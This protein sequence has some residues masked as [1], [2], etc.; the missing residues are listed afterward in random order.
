MINNHIRS[1]SPVVCI[2]GNIL[3]GSLGY[4]AKPGITIK[5]YCPF[6][7]NF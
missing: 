4:M 3:C 2:I 1:K 6:L 5:A 7:F